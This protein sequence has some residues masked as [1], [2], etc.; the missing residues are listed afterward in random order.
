MLATTTLPSFSPLL[1]LQFETEILAKV[2]NE[3]NSLLTVKMLCAI[4]RPMD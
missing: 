1:I 2:G 4:L 3:T